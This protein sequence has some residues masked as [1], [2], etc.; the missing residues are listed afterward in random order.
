MRRI[1]IG[2]GIILFIGILVLQCN[3][4]MTKK[5][6]VGTY[7]NTNYE[8]KTCCLESPHKVDTLKL[9]SDGTFSSGYYGN[10][11]YDINTGLLNT[12]I[13]LHYKY[14]F[15]NAGYYTS[16]NNKIFERPKIMLNS[17][18]NHYYEKSE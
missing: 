12:E 11:T 10:G 5:S 1:L 16:F 18:L 17:D 9:K 15:G 14:E 8:N 13:D 4:P 3:V 7:V 2:I 6:V